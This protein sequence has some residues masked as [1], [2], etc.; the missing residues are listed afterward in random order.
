MSAAGAYKIEDQRRMMRA[1]NYFAWQARMVK[2]EIGKRVIE[3][4]CG[5]GNLTGELLDREAVIALDADPACVDILRSRYP[6]VTALAREVGR[7][8]IADLESFQPDS[9]LFVNVLEHI[10]NERKAI[11]D[12]REVLVDGG[13]VVLLVPAFQSLYGPIDRNLG[14][15]HRY[16]RP[17]IHR[18]AASA[19][20]MVEKLRFV[21]IVGFF[22]WWTNAHFFKRE[23]Q[24]ETQ[25]ELFDRYIVPWVSRMEDVIHPPFGQSLFAVLRK[26]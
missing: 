6:G 24:S 8:R 3:V 14:H 17:A 10:E 7:D 4:G 1:K 16:D 20:L 21:N 26:R 23:A 13:S 9:C 15:F 5:I 2:R 11:A 12:A 22:G 19:D 25:I 18:L